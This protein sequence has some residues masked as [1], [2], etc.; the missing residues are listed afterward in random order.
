MEI[1]SLQILP[2]HSTMTS[3][4]FS[5]QSAK[6]TIRGTIDNSPFIIVRTKTL[7]KGTLTFILNEEDLTRQS[8]KETQLIIDEKLGAGSQ[9]LSRTI[10]HGQH[11]L[12]GLLE[13][14]DAKLKDELSLLNRLCFFLINCY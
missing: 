3:S 9:V 6:V 10:F 2:L 14:T 13:A 12:N 1:S 5:S 11:A 4:S 7:S 8:I